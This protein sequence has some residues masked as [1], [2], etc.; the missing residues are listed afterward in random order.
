MCDISK[1]P[2]YNMRT[3]RTIS[4]LCEHHVLVF[5]VWGVVLAKLVLG[6]IDGRM[7]CEEHKRGD[8]RNFFGV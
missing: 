6:Q 1:L 4:G 5:M 2:L 8:Q 7:T 3:V